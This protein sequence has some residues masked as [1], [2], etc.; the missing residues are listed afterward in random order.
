MYVLFEQFS[1]VMMVPFRFLQCGDL[2]LGA[3]FQYVTCPGT[4]V[5]NT[6]REATFKALDN[7]I[8]VALQE[9]VQFVLITG[10]VYNSE[11]HNLE[12]QIRFVRAM[13]VL[14]ERGIDVYMVQGNHDP[15]ESWQAQLTLP[16]NVHIF[17]HEGP[18]ERYPL[19]INGQEMG[20]IYGMSCGYG[21]ERTHFVDQYKP[22]EDDQF[23]LALMHGSV[24]MAAS[25]DVVGP[26]SLTELVDCGMDYWALGHIHKR[27][28]VKEEPYVVYSGN[29]QGL[30]RKEQGPK[31]CYLVDVNS[32][33]QCHFD[34]RETGAIRFAEAHIDISQLAKEADILEMIRHEKEML[35]KQ[36]DRPV[37]L[38]IVLE[39]RGPLYDLCRQDD[40]RHLWLKDV[41]SSEIQRMMFVMPYRIIDETMPELDLDARRDLQDMVGDYL[42]AYD[43]VEGIQFDE[44]GKRIGSQVALDGDYEGL[45]ANQ[46]RAIVEERAEFKRLGRYGVRITNEMIFRAWR[47]AE[48]EGAMKLLGDR[49]EN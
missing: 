30:H 38:H 40:V 12:A 46:L 13:E 34:F 43:K 16:P 5:S 17:S 36:S 32:A 22:N 7:I 20:G 47:R 29:T 42:M 26:C 35:R 24:G 2:H 1:E 27:S 45:I 8:D 11:D 37:L 48:V 31:G 28:I 44:E 25:K 39:G 10:D 18:A 15:A 9:D 14:N 23:S 19:M 3:P 21:N 49:H 33:G 4:I 6:V 41:Q